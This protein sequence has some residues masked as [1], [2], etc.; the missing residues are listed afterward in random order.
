[1]AVAER[2]LQNGLFDLRTD[3][4][5]VRAAQSGRSDAYATLV[6]RYYPKV[7]SFVSHLLSSYRHRASAP[8]A[9]DLTQEVF[10]RAL[11]ALS[12]F[13]GDYRFGPWL[14]RIARNLCV[15]ETRRDSHRPEPADPIE[16]PNMESS[17]A[18]Q[19]DVWESIS[20]GEVADVVRKA[21]SRLPMRQRTVLI[22]REIEGWSYADIA[23][24]VG[25]NIRGVEATLRRARARFRL[26]ATNFETD[27]NERAI[28]RRVAHLAAAEPSRFTQTERGH[29]ERCEKC[30]TRTSRIRSAEK[31]FGL[32]P[33]LGGGVSVGSGLEA[34]KAKL[35]GVRDFLFSKAEARSIL[36]SP[37]THVA[38]VAAALAVA[39]AVVMSASPAT[40]V[41]AAATKPPT[42]TVITPVFAPVPT[43]SPLRD[44]ATEE[45][46]STLDETA[47]HGTTDEDETDF[48]EKSLIEEVLSVD[49]L[50]SRSNDLPVPTD[51]IT[52]ID[53]DSWEATDAVFDAVDSAT[54][55]V[56]DVVAGLDAEGSDAISPAAGVQP[57][58]IGSVDALDI[59][60]RTLRFSS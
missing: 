48:S 17:A 33:P 6:T 4:S 23:P 60:T 38:E 36:I 22:L 29:I 51:A 16:L 27:E 30:R 43:L 44:V 7:Y 25:T 49:L 21:L 45:E 31:L 41:N 42:I 39:A 24:V 32:M 11:N 19:D 56:T 37:I 55:D 18:A 53:L 20:K 3:K 13:N 58:E 54:G 9:E 12:R 34:F 14:L 1:M 46:S 59:P 15:D 35:N 40:R 28:C 8:S 50:N 26:E 5:L 57:E 10:T 47:P 2:V 52:A